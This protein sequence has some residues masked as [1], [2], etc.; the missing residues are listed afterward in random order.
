VIKI[1]ALLLA[2]GYATRL[3]PLTKDTPKPLLQVGNKKIIDHIIDK[4]NNISEIDEIFVVTNNKF[5]HHFLDW[6]FQNGNQ[7]LRIIND[8]TFTNEDRLGAVG[9]INFVVKLEEINEDLLVIA[10]DNLFGFELNN[11]VNFF[12][13]K[14]S[15]IVAF[16]DLKDKELVK[17]KFGVGLINNEKVINFEEK[18]IEPKSAL[19]AT[20]CY[21]FKKE[22]INFAQELIDEGKGDCPGNLPAKLVEKSI[23]HGYVF[24][25]YWFDI[26]SHDGLDQA[27]KFHEEQQ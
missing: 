7:K 9:D 3:Y 27:R 25:N 19:A 18:P 23:L 16:Y 2:A 26:G 17:G 22:D 13:E 6:A 12:K 5:Y 4:I 10:G 20:A 21:L 24:T 11:F 14:N 1:K 15:S 8:G